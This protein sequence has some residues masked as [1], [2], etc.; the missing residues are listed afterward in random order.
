ALDIARYYR[1]LH[2][3]PTRRS[4]DLLGVDRLLHQAGNPDVAARTAQEEVEPRA[5]VGGG[6]HLP[7]L[8]RQELDE[9]LHDLLTVVEVA[10]E[11][12]ERLDVLLQ[13]LAALLEQT[14]GGLH[15]AAGRL[16]RP[17]DRLPGGRQPRHE[18]LQP[19]D[20]LVQLRRSLVDRGQHRVEVVDHLPDHLVLLGDRG[21]QRRGA[22]Q[23]ALH[24]AALALQ[25]LD[26]LV[27]QLVHVV[28]R[29][30]AEQRLEAVEQL[31]Q[32][33]R[34]RGAFERD[35]VAR[36]QRATRRAVALF[37]RDVALADEVAVLDRRLDAGGQSPAPFDV[38]LD[39]GVPAVDDVDRLD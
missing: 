7:G 9:V 5:V 11:L 4:S 17:A 23:Q 15:R 19:H 30:R 35:R 31:V 29:E 12:T 25:D 28:R 13:R 38:E 33:Q 14:G 10:G 26:D 6:G 20:Q 37:Q 21:G 24:R 16:D 32:V 34:G 8:L 36:L 39:L 18:L 3:F 2:S 1:A 27:R 22:L